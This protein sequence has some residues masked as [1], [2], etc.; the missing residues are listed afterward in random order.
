MDA[1]RTQQAQT[2]EIR[3]FVYG[4]LRANES[5]HHLLAQ[6]PCLGTCTTSPRYH[7]YDT[8]PYP[9]AVAGGYTALTGEVYAVDTA[10]FRQ[11]DILED[12]PR[13]YTRKQIATALGHAWI[14]LWVAPVDP[15][16]RRLPGDWCKRDTQR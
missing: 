3:I 12:Y 14:Y 7:L 10:C 15:R 4:T 1:V 2:Q 11:L 13:S 6:Q 9:A 8:G 16:W 5:N